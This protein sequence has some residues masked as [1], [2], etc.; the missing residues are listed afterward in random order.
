MSLR[1]EVIDYF[2][3][4]GKEIIHRV[5][6]EGS[7]DIK[8]GAQLIVQESQRAVFFR[9]GQAY[10]EFGPGRY[11]LTTANVPLINR[12]LT[13]PW[14]K[15]P[16]QAS[17][18]FVGMQTFIDLKWGTKQPIAYRDKELGLVRLRGFGKFA[19]KV[20][21][22]RMLL[23]TLVGTQGIYTTDQLEDYLRDRIVGR[24]TD[25][26]GTLLTTILDLPGQ[27]DEVAAA[28]RARTADDFRAFGLELT[29]LIIDAITPPEEVEKMMDAR[30][31]MGAVGDL[32]AFMKFQAAKAMT[33]A[34]GGSGV[35]SGAMQAGLGAGMGMMMPGMIKEAMSG[36]GGA[37]GAPTPPAPTP[38][39]AAPT[40]A[41]AKFC[42][43]CGQPVPPGAKFCPGCGKKLG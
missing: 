22:V 10:D 4:S 9:E 6:P 7:A 3:A 25:V 33:E 16:F 5:P 20:G 35:T 11:T 39:P 17:V 24:L 12:I 26:L 41:A 8:Y 21:D 2:D 32:N 14:E 27:Y 43:D 30:A 37:A 18:V 34:A 19:I 29:E 36:G 15:S 23:N 38:A 42:S 1:L 13:F 31:G 28:A 40:S